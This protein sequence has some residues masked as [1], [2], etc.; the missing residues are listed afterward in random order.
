MTE[1]NDSIIDN[2]G[3]AAEQ[4]LEESE[5]IWKLALENVGDGVWDWRVAERRLVF[6]PRWRELLGYAPDEVGETLEDWERLVHPD[7]LADCRRDLQRCLDGDAPVYRN[8]H[9]IRAK[10]GGYRWFLDRGA[11][12]ERG[13][14]DEPLRVVG[15][16]SEVS[17][18]KRPE[19][20][21]VPVAREAHYR[22]VLETAVE[23]VIVIDARGIIQSL[24][25]AAA[26]MFG[27]R[28]EELLGQAINVLMPESYRSKHDQ[29][30]RR[31]LETGEAHVIGYGREL[32]GQHRDGTTF[33]INLSLSRMDLGGRTYFTGLV[34]DITKLKR[35]ESTQ[36]LINAFYCN[37]AVLVT[38]SDN[39][40]IMVNKPFTE[41]TGYELHEVIGKNPSVLSS[42]RQNA[43]FYQDM[44]RSL[45][46]VGRWQ[47]RLWNRRKGGQEYLES[48]AISLIY[49]E[50]GEVF[51]HV[52]VFSEIAASI[53]FS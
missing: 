46:A 27:Y 26:S 5:G 4:R 34:R 33:P 17:E 38:D 7:D 43:A 14:G 28:S 39:H 11:V 32:T 41:V 31:Y 10:D 9:R 51:R 1:E 48:L 22:A 23:G 50:Q 19:E 6:S 8:E 52:A 25:P 49:D 30:I 13:N 12:A 42:G 45:N 15:T 2:P 53:P 18:R 16:Y 40:I 24:S 29:Y 36:Q 21:P 35:S 37:S 20:A 3:P 44:W 47:G